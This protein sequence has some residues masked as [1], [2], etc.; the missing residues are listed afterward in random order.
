MAIRVPI[1]SDFD[2]KGVNRAIQSFSKLKTDLAAADGAMGKFKVASGA[3]FSFAKANAVAFGTAAAAAVAG[4]VVKSVT[5]FQKLTLE[6]GKFSAA[7]GVSVD[8]ASRLIEV[9]SDL[10]INS[11]ALQTGLNKLNRA[12]ADG[13]TAF[14]DIGAQ[15]ARTSGGAVDTQQTFLN[16][17][18][19]LN[20]IQDPA[21]RAQA[22]TKLLGKGW[23]ELAMLVEGGSKKLIAAMKAVENQDLRTPEQVREALKLQAQIEQ[24]KD[25]FSELGKELGKTLIP[26]VL[27][28]VQAI[29]A[30]IGAARNAGDV[31]I[32]GIKVS[33]IAKLSMA[34][35]FPLVAMG[36]AID[37]LNGETAKNVPVTDEMARVWAEGS[38]AMIDGY[39]AA[40]GLTGEMLDLE[41]ATEAAKDEW[42]RLKAVLSLEYQMLTI[43]QDIDGFYAKWTQAMADGTFDAIEYQKELINIQLALLG[44]GAETDGLRGKLA[45]KFKFLV[46]TAQLQRA[47]DLINA[48][49]R[50]L[51]E[52]KNPSGPG[53]GDE[54]LM[55]K[56]PA[57]AAGGIVTGPTVALIG[58]AGPEAV[59]PLD[60]LGG[61]GGNITIN[62]S[63]SVISENDL[64]ETIRRGLVNAQRSG[65][66]LVYSNS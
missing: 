51:R 48:V 32:F 42:N 37:Y 6:V 63:G 7:T 29:N 58:E 8:A 2:E 35:K 61:M 4:F 45:E 3:A 44:I 9:L 62:V 23:Q 10:G 65:S 30:V 60:R 13:A 1:I 11:D 36:Q 12:A 56:I 54:I 18:D 21:L 15:I 25:S 57:M 66:Q 39:M 33:T 16:V 55:S 20:R 24:L 47:L 5:D 26:I 17:I 22:A 28:F 19:A 43:Q 27:D 31:E 14:A 49:K 50:G 64:I 38:Q 34:A 59:I 46:D 40:N 53:S 41:S 52:L